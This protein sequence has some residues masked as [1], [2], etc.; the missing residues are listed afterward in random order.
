MLGAD[1]GVVEPGADRVRFED[2]PVVVGEHHRARAV[3]HADAPGGQRRGVLTAL[4]ALAG[5]LD[6][7]KRDRVVR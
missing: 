5:G 3:E 1:A 4:H 6:A 7:V 2:L